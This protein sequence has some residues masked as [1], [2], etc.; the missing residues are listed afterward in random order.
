MDMTHLK[1]DRGVRQCLVDIGREHNGG[2]FC[3]SCTIV[4]VHNRARG[5]IVVLFYGTP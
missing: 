1:L 2:D 3:V 4:K 5:G